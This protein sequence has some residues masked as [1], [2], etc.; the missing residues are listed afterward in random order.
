MKSGHGAAWLVP[1]DSATLPA[2]ACCS[3]EALANSVGGMKLGS[4]NVDASLSTLPDE[5]A[6]PK[7]LGLIHLPT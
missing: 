6:N 2:F 1:E 5:P 7:A 3:A 4:C